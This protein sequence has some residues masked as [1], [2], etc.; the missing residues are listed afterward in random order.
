MLNIDQGI[1][2]ISKPILSERPTVSVEMPKPEPYDVHVFTEYFGHGWKPQDI[3]AWQQSFDADG[4][5]AYLL[6]S[7]LAAPRDGW[8]ITVPN[9]DED[10]ILDPSEGRRSALTFSCSFSDCSLRLYD[11]EDLLIGTP[12]LPPRRDGKTAVAFRRIEKTAKKEESAA[13][14]AEEVTAKIVAR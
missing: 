2:R 9:R 13:V 8:Y 6:A 1:P 5:N 3:R 7:V 10:L 14:P 11:L 4:D 12:S